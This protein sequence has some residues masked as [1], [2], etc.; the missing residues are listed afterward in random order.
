[1]TRKRRIKEK[2]LTTRL[3]KYFESQEYKVYKEVRIPAKPPRY[4]DLL[5]INGKMVA[6]EVKV[7]DWKTALRQANIYTLIADKVYIGIWKEKEKAVI[8]NLSLLEH[9]GIG[10]IT[11]GK[12][13]DVILEASENNWLDYNLRQKILQNL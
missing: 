7:S 11:I 5:A 10:L 4:I 13:V 1:M 2:T 6:V 12:S 9:F 3:A 8:K